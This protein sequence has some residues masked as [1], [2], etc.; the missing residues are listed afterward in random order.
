MFCRKCGAEIPDDSIFCI[1]CGEQLEYQSTAEE[2]DNTMSFENTISEDQDC[3]LTLDEQNKMANDVLKWGILGAAFAE[4]V[5]FLGIP[6]S[7]KAKKLAAEY[8]FCKCKK[9]T[10]VT[11]G[12]ILGKVGFIVSL[13]GT[14]VLAAYLSIY[15][16]I[17]FGMFALILGG[18]L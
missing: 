6:F 13:V 7:A 4:N 15:F 9:D 14:I 8:E 17:Y 5:I 3:A 11:V 1:R 18:S 16:S 10:R 2:P 12:K